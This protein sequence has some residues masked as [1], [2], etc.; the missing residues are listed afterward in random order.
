M[1]DIKGTV[2]VFDPSEAAIAT[3]RAE[4]KPLV[5]NPDLVRTPE[6]YEQTKIARRKLQKARTAIDERR[7]SLG[8]DAREWVKS[9]NEKARILIGTITEYEDVLD[10]RIKAVDAEKQVAA[11]AAANKLR[12]ELEAKAQAERDA[13]EARLKAI[14]DAENERL[15][16]AAADL[17]RQQD[18]F[19]AQQQAAVAARQRDQEE[20]AARRAAELAEQKAEADRVRAEQKAESDRLAA[21]QK[22]MDDEQAEIDRHKRTIERA[23]FERKA[24]EEAQAQAEKQAA[25]KAE[26]EAVAEAKRKADADRLALIQIEEDAAERKRLEESLP[27]V[28][29]IHQYGRNIAAIEEGTLKSVE[30]REFMN[31]MYQEVAHIAG[32]CTRYAA[33][34]KPARR[35]FGK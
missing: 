2:V 14:R 18:E 31:S 26:A 16:A 4:I 28:E 35:S 1:D 17:K 15:A 29:K 32:R 34:K 3:M 6:G 21:M 24:R 11:I 8:A 13:E 25:A 23:E 30:A 22:K 12:E 5:D 7:L 33:S 27:D 9:V 20:A 10:S 19:V